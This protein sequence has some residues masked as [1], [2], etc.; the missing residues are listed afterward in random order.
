MVHE[1]A[2]DVRGN[3]TAIDKRPAPGPVEIGSLGLVGD[4]R[5]SSTHGGDGQAVYAYASED[6]AWWAGELGRDVPP[7]WFGENLRVSGIDVTGAVIGE[8]W[9][10]GGSGGGVLLEVTAPRVPCATFQGWVDQPRWVKRFT[11]R[12]TPGAYL[13]VLRQG[14]LA[15]GDPIE[16]Q[17]RP[18]HAVTIGDAFQRFTPT[19]A[20]RLLDAAG[21]GAID[22]HGPV[23]KAA[24]AAL[25]RG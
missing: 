11:E 13:R 18:E 8:R 12:G 17:A 25:D 7:G 19:T 21:A 9:L 1:V 2:L 22:L 23:R 14:T 16:V 3:D 20:R 24:Q 15:A 5:C 10:L 6:A 4:R